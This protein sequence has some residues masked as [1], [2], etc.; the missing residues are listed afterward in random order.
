MNKKIVNK[1]LK[2]R[3]LKIE[4]TKIPLFDGYSFT[5]KNQIKK[6]NE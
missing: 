4:D 6:V 1:I 2:S 3:G 5:I